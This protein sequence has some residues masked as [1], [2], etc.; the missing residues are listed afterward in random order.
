MNEQNL[1]LTC[2]TPLTDFQFYFLSVTLSYFLYDL[3]WINL[4]GAEPLTI[5]L[6][7]ICSIL[8]L[9][10]VLTSNT[11]GP[12]VSYGLF[13]LE[14]TNPYLQTRWF[15]RTHGYQNKRIHK[16]VE[17]WFMFT[18]IVIRVIGGTLLLYFVEIHPNM[19]IILKIAFIGIYVVSWLLVI[20]ILQ[21]FK[22]KYIEESPLLSGSVLSLLPYRRRFRN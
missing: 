13:G 4:F 14:F 16:A 2:N 20:Q 3:L 17:M 21:F 12:G 1:D 10:K 7:H 8:L 19:D 11:G 15:L 22:R 18:F 6:H 9:F 5:Y